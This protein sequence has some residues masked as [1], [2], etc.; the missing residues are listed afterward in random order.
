MADT[1]GPIT[2]Q[3]SLKKRW[4]LTPLEW[5]LAVAVVAE[6]MSFERAASLL[7]RYGVKVIV[8]EGWVKSL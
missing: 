8:G 2:L 5:A 7:V 3:L 1:V 4:W 6:L